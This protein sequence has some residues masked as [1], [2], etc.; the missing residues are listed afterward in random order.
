EVDGSLAY[1]PWPE[2]G[3]AQ[4][5][6]DADA[7]PEQV[8]H[9]RT[10]TGLRPWILPGANPFLRDPAQHAERPD[11]APPVVPESA[12]PELDDSA[13]SRS[14]CPTTGRSPDRSSSTARTEAWG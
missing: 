2:L 11:Q 3:E 1:V 7:R 14:P 4:D 13:G 10:S 8:R 9:E 12:A 6:K 5:G